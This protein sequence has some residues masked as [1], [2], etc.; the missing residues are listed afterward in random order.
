MDEKK[1]VEAVAEGAD[2]ILKDDGIDIMAKIVKKAKKSGTAIGF[3]AGLLVAG[4]YCKVVRPAWSKV[5]ARRSKNEEV[6]DADVVE[7]EEG[8]DE[9]E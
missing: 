1:V 5:A 7:S 4:L 9:E 8:T 6:V 2:V 3:A